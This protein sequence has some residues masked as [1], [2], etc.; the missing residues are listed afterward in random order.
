MAL[1]KLASLEG[2]LDMLCRLFVAAARQLA[3][4][5]ELHARLYGVG[6]FTALA[7]WGW[8]GGGGRFS[9]VC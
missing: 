5:K 3:G 1:D 4:A 8:L 7:L 9:S 2:H 6:P